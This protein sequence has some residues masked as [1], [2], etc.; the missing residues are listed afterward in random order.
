MSFDF[1]DLLESVACVFYACLLSIDEG[2]TIVWLKLQHFEIPSLYDI[3]QIK[4]TWSKYR[5]ERPLWSWLFD[6]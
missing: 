6:I 3:I 2:D 4:I 1:P 5:A